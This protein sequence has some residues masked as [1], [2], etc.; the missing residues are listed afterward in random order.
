MHIRFKKNKIESAMTFGH[1]FGLMASGRC[2][3]RWFVS[4]M[5]QN[6]LFI[7]TKNSNIRLEMKSQTNIDDA[8]WHFEI[9][10][11]SEYEAKL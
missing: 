7:H 1:P 11:V 6:L 10:I 5:N 9:G 3:V 4:F 8:K 2:P